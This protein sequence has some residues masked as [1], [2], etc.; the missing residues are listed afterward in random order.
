MTVSATSAL[1]SDNH[2]EDGH[3]DIEKQENLK[4][5]EP[6]INTTGEVVSLENFRDKND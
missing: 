4:N 3:E 2:R 1:A 6:E 5:Q